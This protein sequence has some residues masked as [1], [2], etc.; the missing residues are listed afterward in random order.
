MKILIFILLLIPGFS[1]AS[2]IFWIQL[3]INHTYKDLSTNCQ[4]L[5]PGGRVFFVAEIE[6]NKIKSARL[7]SSYLKTNS[8]SISL[9]AQEVSQIELY[10]DSVKRYWLKKILLEE[11][12]LKWAF[13]YASRDFASYCELPQQIATLRDRSTIFDF[14]LDG[15]KDGI[16]TSYSQELKTTGTRTDNNEFKASIQLMQREYLT[17]PGGV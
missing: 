3:H 8:R 2:E 1:K 11:A 4:S 16:D 9:T 17:Y 10:Q 15:I 12:A 14:E 7:N 13:Y 6:N 5:K